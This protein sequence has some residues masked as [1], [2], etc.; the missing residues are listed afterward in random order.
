MT[1]KAGD[2]KV[3]GGKRWRVLS[4]SAIRDAW[5]AEGY[6]DEVNVAIVDGAEDS[7]AVPLPIWEA[8]AGEK[9]PGLLT[10]ADKQWIAELVGRAITDAITDAIE[11]HRE[12]E[13]QEEELAWNG[14]LQ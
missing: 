3:I 9:A 5:R 11:R 4:F 6:P 7:W 2:V 8:V 13:Q 1:T 10:A 12:Q 14:C